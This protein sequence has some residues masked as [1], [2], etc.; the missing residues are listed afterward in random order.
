MKPAI[1]FFLP[2]IAT[3]IYTMADKTMIGLITHSD[4]QNGLYEQAHKIEQILVQFLLS[5]G[6]VYRSEMARLF[7]V[8]D[9]EKAENNIR[10]A[11]QLLLL[12]SFPVCTGLISI[13]REL[14]GWFL[15][16]KYLECIALLRVFSVLLV[17]ISIS[18]CMSNMYLIVTEK[19]D[20]FRRGTYSGAV[21]NIACNV[22][23][24]PK[25]GA[26]GAAVSSVIAETV[27]LCVFY[28]YSKQL[29]KWNDYLSEILKYIILCCFMFFLIQLEASV[30]EPYRFVSLVAE[31]LSGIVI[32]FLG[33]FVIRDDAFLLY[34]Q[35]L[36][37]K[38]SLM[39][40]K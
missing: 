24:I 12:I 40:K 29:F 17:V 20:K 21:V 9:Y 38:L 2:N 18:N 3:M 35:L 19:Q 32:Y 16:D 5:I 8:K 1:A 28:Y 37:R 23:L 30:L 4:Y 33:L 39:L 6:V 13:S 22:F 31:V 14:I 34:W 10:R 15:G 27:I 7:A 11:M 26:L 36:K 25:Y